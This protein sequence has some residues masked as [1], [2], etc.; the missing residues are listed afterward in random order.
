[1]IASE[2][3]TCHRRLL[4]QVNWQHPKI[5]QGNIDQTELV[6]ADAPTTAMPFS[7]GVIGD[8][9]PG[10]SETQ[11]MASEAFAEQLVQQLRESRFLLHTGDVAYPVG[12]YESYLNGFLRPYRALLSSLP[13]RC[14]YR[15]D[16]IVFKRPLLP[17]PGNHDCADLPKMARWRHNLLRF[18]SD[19]LRHL[20]IDIGCYGGYGG[21]AY[22]QTFLDDLY[23]LSE[24]QLTTHL[25]TR[26]DA[27]S[28]IS[29]RTATA[30]GSDHSS[31]C[32]SYQ[33]EKFTRLPNRYYRF[34]Y[35]G[36]DFFALDSNTWNG[37]PEAA[38]FDHEQL[39]WL[40]QGLIAS[41]QTP[42]T[43]GRIIYLHHSPYTTEETRWQQSETLW[44]RRHLRSVLNRVAARLNRTVLEDPKTNEISLNDS[45][46]LA[47]PLVDLI[48]SGHA[49]CLE[50]VRTT[51]TG[52]ADAHLDW[53]VCGGS[54]ASPRRRRSNNSADI[55][56]RLGVHAGTPH[57]RYTS[58]VAKSQCYVSAG[59]SRSQGRS[60]IRVDVTP[61]GHQ[62]FVVRPFV[63]TRS[64]QGWQTC[65]L[66]ALDVGTA[67]SHY[68]LPVYP[69]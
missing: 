5:I 43:F 55:L 14:T 27:T 42:S 18:L 36:V 2:R 38:E 66:D 19:R 56:E 7:F 13:E 9:D 60:F 47:P 26:Y 3:F 68:V 30:R 25:A 6:I 24:E 52:H 41:L 61:G 58:V 20:N 35:G 31:Y 67:R 59:E 8:T 17:V 53:I 16:A 10:S 51:N 44:V 62:K 33:P 4:R 29:N 45:V 64:S 65:A 11:S 22:G 23:K 40:E 15:S 54:G 21:E 57:R 34:R 37:S 12:S 50:Y 69:R 1:M 28:S 46:A 49:H 32:L 48:V 63:V 39:S